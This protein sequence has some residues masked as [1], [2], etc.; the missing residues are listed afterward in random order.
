MTT[1]K[2]SMNK[3]VFWAIWWLRGSLCYASLGIAPQSLIRDN[4]GSLVNHHRYLF[5]SRVPIIRFEYHTIRFATIFGGTSYSP[6]HSFGLI[7]IG[8]VV[9][10]HTHGFFRQKYCAFTFFTLIFFGMKLF[11]SHFGSFDWVFAPTVAIFETGNVRS[12]HYIT[13]MKMPINMVTIRPV[14]A[15]I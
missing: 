3:W 2:K 4:N 9:G 11:R 5:S 15:R 7:T 8:S 6:C 13:L 12:S 1:L 10:V 14:N